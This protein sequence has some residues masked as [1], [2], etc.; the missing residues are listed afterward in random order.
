MAVNGLLSPFIGAGFYYKTFMWPAAFWER[1]YEPLIRRAAG[2]GRGCELRGRLP[3]HEIDDERLRHGALAPCV[4]RGV[5][6]REV[7]HVSKK[8]E[9]RGGNMV[10]PANAS[11]R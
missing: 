3:R 11:R 4:W 6:N 9:A 1:V 2:L 8:K 5:G 7:P 10:S